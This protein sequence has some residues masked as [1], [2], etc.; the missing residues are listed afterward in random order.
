MTNWRC[1]ENPSVGGTKDI[2]G[3][4]RCMPS[5]GVGAVRVDAARATWGCE[6]KSRVGGRV[7]SR[8]FASEESDQMDQ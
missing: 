7:N 2:V 3:S 4:S 6:G 5:V 8:E 1:F